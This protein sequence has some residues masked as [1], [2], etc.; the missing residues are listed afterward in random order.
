MLIDIWVSIP[1]PGK[2]NDSP[3]TEQ[4][5]FRALLDTGATMSA[6]SKKVVEKVGLVPGGWRLITGVHATG[7]TPTCSVGILVPVSEQAP[8]QVQIHM[9]GLEKM[10]VSVLEFQPE[11]FDVLP[12]MDILQSCH[13][14]MHGGVFVLSI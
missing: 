7:K 14:S 4:Y 5:S 8:E 12:G 13:L 10:E 3:P 1:K 11:D 2:E 6:I 9:R